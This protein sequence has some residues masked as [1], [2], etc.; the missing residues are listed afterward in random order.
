MITL[1]P[2]PQKAVN[3]INK[4]NTRLRL[5]RQAEQA[6]HELVRLAEPLVREHGGGDVDER[7]AGLFREGFGEHGF[8]AAG[9]TVE[10]DAF[11]GGKEGGGGGEKGG[12]E[13]GEDDGFAEGGDY[14]IQ[15]ADVYRMIKRLICE[16][17]AS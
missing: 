12:V 1:T 13:E 7:R 6:R 14:F 4:N 16:R 11:G 17:V 10:Q 3:L 9:W 15:P 8:A 5:P 2:L